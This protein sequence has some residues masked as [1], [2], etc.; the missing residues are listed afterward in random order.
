LKLAEDRTRRV[1]RSLRVL[2][3]CS[4]GTLGFDDEPAYL[5][6][7]CT[8]VAAAGGYRLAWVGRAADDPGR[9]LRVLARAGE[10]ETGGEPSA[11]ALRT[12]RTQVSRPGPEMAADT[13]G[14]DGP[15]GDGSSIALPLT[16]G[17]AVVGVL[18]LHAVEPDAFN[19]EEI[20]PLEELARNVAAGIEALRTRRERDLAEGANRAKSQF[21]AAMSHEI[22]TPLNA[23]VGLNDLIRRDGVTPGQAAWL[24]KIDSAGQHLLSVIDD[25][26]DLS[27]IEA[28]RV[29]IESI[30]FHLSAVLDAVQSIIAEPA[31]AKGLA[32][33]VT[34]RAVP[35]WLRGDPTRLRQALLNFAGNAVKFTEQGSVTLGAE[36]LEDRGDE[37]L[38]RFSVADT[39]IGIA[40]RDLPRLFQ[41]FEQ[42]DQ[43]VTRRF[44][45]TGL[46]LAITRRLAELMQGRC[47]VDSEPGVG[48]TF[49]FTAVLH[50]GRAAPPPPAASGAA[51]AEALLH[52][53][54]GGARVLLVEDNEVNREVALAMLDRVGLV[55]EMAADGQEAVAKARAAA[56]E[57]VLMDMQMPVM[58]GLEATRLIRALPGW[59]ARPILALTAN[60]FDDDRAA[61]RAAGMNDF[62]AKPMRAQTLYAALLQWLDLARGPAA[63]AAP[64]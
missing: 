60:A 51:S 35:P 11:R 10:G 41:P 64:G 24:D 36:L 52:T 40:A 37:L 1:N 49:W 6:Q 39:G 26:L 9:P 45:G 62:I 54:H 8:A 46:G 29:Q 14:A 33:A 38:V 7:V 18:S 13:P 53:R 63:Q 23:I 28:G 48:S 4:M 61:C 19:P 2:G 50:R 3:S 47:G 42:A 32:V 57:L 34:Q 20:P 17:P 16:L 15:G 43:S 30:E 55:V 21:L 56:Y 27:K 58:G 44:G 59:Q 31:R 25:I 22:R 12:G 5:A